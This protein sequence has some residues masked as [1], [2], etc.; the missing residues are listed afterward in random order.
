MEKKWDTVIPADLKRLFLRGTCM[1]RY[2]ERV[3]CHTCP[4][5]SRKLS[6]KVI[7]SH[8]FFGGGE[9][10]GDC[11]ATSFQRNLLLPCRVLNGSCSFLRNICDVKASYSRPSRSQYSPSWGHENSFKPRYKRYRQWC[12]IHTAFSREY[13]RLSLVGPMRLV[14]SRG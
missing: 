12:E 10:G 7:Q 14:R 1:S 2:Q 5:G 11:N 9:E 8:V 6:H 3:N 4:T 13:R